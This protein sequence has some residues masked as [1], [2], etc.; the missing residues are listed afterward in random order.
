MTSSPELTRR[1]MILSSGILL[2]GVSQTNELQ[3][4]EPEKDLIF[5]T[6]DPRNAEP[7]LNKLITSWITPTKHFYVRS[8]A[9]N[10]KIDP[11]TFR[12]SVEGMV[13]KPLSLSLADIQSH[14]EYTLTATLTCAGNRRAEFNEEGKVGG[15]QWDAGAIGNA[16]WTGVA[17][18]EILGKAGVQASA[19]HVWFEGLDEITKG[20]GI[21]PFGASIPLE[22]ALGAG[23]DV[24]AL[25]CY[26][27]NGEALTADHGYPLR[28]LV[29]GYIGARSV[30]WL[31]KIVVSDVTSPNHYL[32]NAYKLVKRTESIDWSESGPIYRYLVN[33]A[34]GS[35]EKGTELEAGKADL[36]GY[37][38]P[39]GILGSHVKRVQVSVNNGKSWKKAELTGEDS[40]FCWQLWKASVQVTEE[41]KEIAVRAE[42]SSGGFMPY[43]VPWNAKGYLQ[44]S[45][46]RLPV[47]VKA[48]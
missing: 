16:T 12:L 10:P 14:Q 2:A 23:D 34:V 32:A 37:V 7:A 30:K 6:T 43:R 33:A 13:D 38:L 21:I 36:A 25:L 40:D 28:T 20:D 1:Q 22:K 5:R 18:S 41:T 27:M 9:P 17:L 24:G 15:V 4:Q 26:G 3:A 44:N 42:D 47:T 31:G 8:H 46:Y 35:H 45:W 39:S 19:R 48:T 29:P 11:K